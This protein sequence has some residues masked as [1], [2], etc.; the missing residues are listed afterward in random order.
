[1][2]GPRSDVLPAPP[3]TVR[4][5]GLLDFLSIQA[6]GRYPQHL[7]EDLSPSIDLLSWF[8]DAQAETVTSA[9]LAQTGAGSSTVGFTVPNG[10]AWL[11]DSYTVGP[12]IVGALTTRF[13]N[14]ICVFDSDG[15][16]VRHV[17]A[18]APYPFI[19]ADSMLWT[20][21]PP[22]PQLWLP[23]TPIG[24]TCIVSAGAGTTTPSMRLRIVRCSV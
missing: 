17:L 2:A 24:L 10:E 15:V 19:A 8:F 18:T 5:S 7:L 11:V 16:T 21:I 23:G 13:L 6:G 4:P 22:Q 3:L 20:F 12:V 14:G 9:A 1:M